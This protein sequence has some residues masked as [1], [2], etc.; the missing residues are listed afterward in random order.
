VVTTRERWQLEGSSSEAYEELL[1]PAIFRPWAGPLVDMAE[2][3][4]GERVLDVACG[5][6]IVA[7]TA[8]DRVGRGGPGTVAGIDVNATMLATARA[9]AGDV[10]IEWRE[11][12]AGALPFPDG[13]FDAVFCQQALQFVA[14]REEAAGE[15][16]R[17]LAPGGRAAVAVWCA[18]EHNRA[19]ALF[20]E[21]LGRHSRQAGDIMRAPFGWGDREA[22]RND[23]SSGGFDQD[24]VRIVLASMI[25]RF[26]SPTEL[27]RQEM[28]S[29]PIAGPLGELDDQAFAA[30]VAD[31][32][33]T[34]EPYCDDDGVAIPME[35]HLAIAS[36]A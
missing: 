30:L 7:R 13:S 28:L 18:L 31:V 16:H 35:A 36:V 27:L 3:Q 5:T 25:S 2:L 29:S 6:G 15:M 26:P 33:E 8:A 11:A 23:L 14:A 22:L 32:E 1:V 12:D 17:V 19:F 34:M 21:A 10:P 20:A 24:R 4:P 9:S